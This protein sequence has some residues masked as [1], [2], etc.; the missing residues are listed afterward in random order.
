MDSQ[1]RRGGFIH[2]RRP[3][4]LIR[5][6]RVHKIGPLLPHPAEDFIAIRENAPASRRPDEIIAAANVASSADRVLDVPSLWLYGIVKH[7]PIQRRRRF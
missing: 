6:A 2:A 7:G 4:E 1:L 3:R 5:R